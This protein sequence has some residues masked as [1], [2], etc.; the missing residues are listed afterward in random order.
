[1]PFILLESYDNYITA[2]MRLQ[3]LE[4][5]GIKSYLQD[6]NTVTIDPMLSNAI[7]GI[8]LMVH[9]EDFVRAKKLMEEL[10]AAYLKSFPCP[11]CGAPSLQRVVETNKAINWLSSILSWAFA[12]Y[13]VPV[14]YGYKCF[15][16]GHEMKELPTRPDIQE[17]SL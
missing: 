3:Q 7:G 15:Q 2:N 8:K 17:N 14:T 11:N 1:M 12:S 6:E 4:E 10:D 9:D 13:A 5:E 16:C